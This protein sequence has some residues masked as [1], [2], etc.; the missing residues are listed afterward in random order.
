MKTSVNLM[1]SSG[2]GPLEL[3]PIGKWRLG[4]Y[5]PIS[6]SHWML[7]GPGRQRT[8][9]ETVFFKQGDP[10]KGLKADSC[11]QVALS[12][13]VGMSSSFPKGSRQRIIA[14][15]TDA[16]H[17]NF[18]SV[19]SGSQYCQCN[20][21]RKTTRIIRIRKKNCHYLQIIWLPKKL[22]IM[23]RNIIIMNKRQLRK[24]LKIR[25]IYKN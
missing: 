9:C 15:N 4:L 1:A 20:K 18:Y 24:W 21:T 14:A 22:K 19:L 10:Q 13:A 25:V 12:V 17:Y 8:L 11:L 3:Y 5:I 16:H 7:V 2:S 23:Y 6:I